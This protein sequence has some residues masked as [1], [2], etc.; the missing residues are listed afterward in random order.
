MGLR[1]PGS[2]FCSFC[3]P[4]GNFLRVLSQ[5]SF[6]STDD[7][8]L[9]LSKSSMS[10]R[11]RTFAPVRW[12]QLSCATRAASGKIAQPPRFWQRPRCEDCHGVWEV[13]ACV[14][15]HSFHLA[16]Y[17]REFHLHESDQS[18]RR[19]RRHVDNPVVEPFE[20][21]RAW[22]RGGAVESNCLP[23]NKLVGVVP[24]R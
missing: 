24:I 3:F 14:Y 13:L 8:G 9:M 5:Q 6:S 15:N 16:A 18:N 10:Y 22:R 21:K 12:K 17:F 4:S 20:S 23:S 7:A 2:P 19:T 1:P 11:S